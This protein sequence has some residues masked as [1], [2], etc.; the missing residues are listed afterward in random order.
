MP[1]RLR[2]HVPVLQRALPQR[3]ER[4][5]AWRPLSDAEW[6]LARPWVLALHQRGRPVAD[7]RARLDACL[8]GACLKGAWKELPATFGRADTIHRQFR[9]WGEAGLWEALLH[10]VAQQ[11]RE[12]SLAGLAYFVCRAFRRAHRILGLRG[13]RLARA[14]GMDSALRAP[15]DW[16]PDPDLSE[17]YHVTFLLPGA[18]ALHRW[19]RA[20]ALA[21]IRVWKDMLTRMKG[22]ARI[23]RWMAPA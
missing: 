10:A 18:E 15:R 21:A 17:H 12:P 6:A 3:F 14:L 13:L 1:R 23:A 2:L 4:P 7:L 5:V 19:P 8:H 22:R 11:G 9:R 20:V 16:L